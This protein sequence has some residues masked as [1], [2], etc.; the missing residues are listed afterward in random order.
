[1]SV[2]F[3]LSEFFE[4]S[5]NT[6][7]VFSE[8][9]RDAVVGFA[10]NIWSSYPGYITQ[11]TNPLSSFARGFM[12]SA[13][14][15]VQPA[16]P[17]PSVPFTGGQCTELYNVTI[18]YEQSNLTTCGAFTF[19]NNQFN[20]MGP[21][22]GLRLE[23]ELFIP[24]DPP[25]VLF[26]ANRYNVY[27]QYNG[28]ASEIQINDHIFDGCGNPNDVFISNIVRS[29]GMPDNCGNPPVSYP[30][31]PPSS[32]DLTTIIN[33]TNGD[34]IDNSYTVVFNKTQNSY[35]FPIS[36]K[37]NGVNATLDIGGLTI[38]G[39]VNVTTTT[40]GN[41][42][43][44]P[45]SDG[46]DDGVGGNNDTVYDD[47]EYPVIP[48]LVV[49][50]TTLQAFNYLRCNTDVLDPIMTTIKIASSSIP[51]L[52]LL[53]EIILDVLNDTCGGGN[54]EALV[55]LPE[56]Y[57]VKPGTNRPAIV[58]L[59][60]EVIGGTI[61]ASTYSSTVTYPTAAAVSAIDTIVVPDKTIGTFRTSITLTDGV[62][63]L[64]TG[65]T[66]ANADINFNFLIGQV[67]PT[68]LPMDI[69]GNT[70]RGQDTRLQVKTLKC[71]QIE[72]Y[73]AGKNA[74]VNPAQRRVID[75]T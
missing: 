52:N 54:P 9:L 65:D 75:I 32:N 5:G 38:F 42:P 28:G 46:G 29:D 56:Y 19:T 15:P 6:A 58:Y 34:T 43:L 27:L 25:N 49:P 18:T 17:A 36:F 68:F 44:P 35:N 73:P 59:W 50:Q 48:D 69:P 11:G 20:L 24:A 72:Y 62:R 66:Q 14:S 57:N 39:D 3:P 70:T 26:D 1:M 16:V 53:I 30:G 61:Q 51:W 21:I 37:I 71:R 40:T 31:P 7:A 12:N 23:F 55:G 33:I 67:D 10:C 45:G 47:T 64:S 13:C 8:N 63:I 2:V 22:V 41:D 74:N 60:K 4:S